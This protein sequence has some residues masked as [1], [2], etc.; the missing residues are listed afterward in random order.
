VA[1]LVDARDLKCLASVDPIGISRKT[2]PF[3]PIDSDGTKR[4][5]Q[6]ICRLIVQGD[7][8]KFAIGLADDAPGPFPSRRFAESVAARLAVPA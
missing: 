7:D 6:N 1:E 4:D 2:P 5:L 3:R 8:G